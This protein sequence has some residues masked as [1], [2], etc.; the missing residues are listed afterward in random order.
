M[1]LK[2]IVDVCISLLSFCFNDLSQFILDF[3]AYLPFHLGLFDCVLRIFLT[4]STIG[5]AKCSTQWWLSYSFAGID[6]CFNNKDKRT[7]PNKSMYKSITYLSCVFIVLIYCIF[8]FPFVF[9]IFHLLKI[10][11]FMHILYMI[12]FK[13]TFV[14][15][16]PFF[17]LSLI[18][19]FKN[20][21]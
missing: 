13:N 7:G 2:K 8:V 20:S 15:L 9:C 16:C 18:E 6:S 21:F 17:S 4:V 12:I 11:I 3:S 19:I 1:N 10:Y 14:F 5:A